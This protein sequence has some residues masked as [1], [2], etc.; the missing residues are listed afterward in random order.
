MDSALE[1]LKAKLSRYTRL[2]SVMDK[3]VE[4]LVRRHNH[5]YLPA[6]SEN[7]GSKRSTVIPDTMSNRII[8]RITFQEKAAAQLKKIDAEMSV[9][10]D[11]VLELEDGLEQQVILLR[12]ITGINDGA[13]LMP[14]REIAVK[15]YGDDGDA[16]MQ[17][18]FRTHKRALKNIQRGGF[19]AD[20]D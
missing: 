3:L 17:A 14:W 13:Q 15:V 1:G 7:D 10:E 12:Y 18:V 19:Y 16:Q 20:T 2:K 9:I 5:Q 6:R 11:A 4:E 8:S